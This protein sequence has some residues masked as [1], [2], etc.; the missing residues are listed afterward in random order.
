MHADGTELELKVVGQIEGE[1]FVRSYQRGYRWGPEEVGQLLDD[2]WEGARK[3]KD[4]RYCLQPVVVKRL[5]D[6]RFE[7][8]DGQQRLTTLFLLYTYLRREGLK[9][10][11]QPYVIHYETRERCA[12]FLGTLGTAG[13]DTA[14]GNN[15]DFFHLARAYAVIVRWFT[16]HGRQRQLAADEM[17]RHLGRNVSVVWYKAPAEVDSN[18]LFRRLN[19]GRIPL[20]N[21]ELIKALLFTGEMSRRE[22]VAAQWDGIERDLRDPDRWAFLTNEPAETYPTRIQLL[23]DLMAGGH[24]ATRG[25]AYFSFEALR[26][27]IVQDPRTFWNQVLELHARVREWFDD[28]DLYHWVGFLVAAGEPLQA[29]V[30]TSATLRRS[31]FREHVSARI[32]A[33]LGQS[34]ASLAKL[35]YEHDADKKSCQRVLL[36]MNVETVRAV[37]HSTER[38]S[39]L[40]HKRRGWSLE[41]IHAQ[42]AEALR[43]EKARRAWL[44]EHRRALGALGLE[45]ATAAS[46][47]ARMAAEDAVSNVTFPLL[48][49]EVVRA[50]TLAGDL[51]TDATHGLANLALLARDDNS[52]LNNSV[53]EVKRRLILAL[54]RT[55]AYIP[56][57]TRRVFL[58]YYSPAAGDHLHFWGP[59][60]REGYMAAMNEVLKPFLTGLGPDL[61]QEDA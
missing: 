2:L 21:A 40:Q 49:A 43:G 60:D 22:E 4:E 5:S 25:R 30:D 31:Q 19:H 9:N 55:G 35:S 41:H 16:S 10:I 6:T 24:G 7:L 61:P 8:V 56:V 11:D 39:F 59:A 48:V 45:A 36:L 20:T 32:R 38:Y 33:L 44:D 14:A 1:F 13:G 27:R 37:P 34:H 53:F 54:D 3:A 52:A 18:T 42:H 28:R 12:E 51:Q 58:K 23:F 47:D 29:L 57:C 26:E 50:Y 17:Y 15:I 46:L